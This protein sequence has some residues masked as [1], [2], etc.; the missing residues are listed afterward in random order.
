[1]DDQLKPRTEDHISLFTRLRV[2]TKGSEVFHVTARKTSTISELLSLIEAEH[3]F[4]TS[5]DSITSGV[6]YMLTEDR[7]HSTSSPLVCVGLL[8]DGCELR[9]DDL[10]G[11][12]LSMDSLVEVVSEPPI[13]ELRHLFYNQAFVSSF[14]PFCQNANALPPVLFW[15]EVEMIKG[16]HNSLVKEYIESTFISNDAPLRLQLSGSLKER[17]SQIYRTVI[18]QLMLRFIDSTD[19]DSYCEERLR[20]SDLVST[21]ECF[22]RN[23]DLVAGKLNGISTPLLL[24][25]ISTQFLPS[26]TITPPLSIS[27]TTISSNPRGS[28]PPQSTPVERKLLVKRIR[29]LKVLLGENVTSEHILYTSS[30]EASSSASDD[31]EWPSSP[32]PLRQFKKLCNV[33]GGPDG[34]YSLSGEAPMQH[35]V[36]RLGRRRSNTT[37]PTHTFKTKAQVIRSMDKL[38]D[39]L[40]ERP[41]QCFTVPLLISPPIPCNTPAHQKRLLKLRKILGQNVKFPSPPTL[42]KSVSA[43]DL[44]KLS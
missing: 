37:I 24:D 5:I 32:T 15:L 12:V 25:V 28:F 36:P 4:Q 44:T 26:K 3:A 20:G 34:L 2:Q 40:G 16:D 13:P 1:M 18:H 21:A 8:H 11:E 29:K 33:L 9:L 6:K 10:V 39:I 43:I 38:Q 17:Q 31:E 35:I 30:A 19:F 7:Q 23:H 22:R 41:P 27:D 42:S 14:L